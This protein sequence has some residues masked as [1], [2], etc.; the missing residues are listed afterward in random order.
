MSPTSQPLPSRRLP[1]A[2]AGQCREDSSDEPRPGLTPANT[3]AVD[4]DDAEEE[5][6]NEDEAHEEVGEDVTGDD[7]GIVFPSDLPRGSQRYHHGYHRGD[8]DRPSLL[9]PEGTTPVQGA[10]AS[11]Y[12]QDFEPIYGSPKRAGEDHIGA[13]APDFGLPH[14]MSDVSLARL[15]LKDKPLAPPLALPS[16]PHTQPF[17][18]DTTDL[19]ETVDFTEPPTRLL[20]AVNE[21]LRS[22]EDSLPPVTEDD[23]GEHASDPGDYFKHESEWDEQIAGPKRPLSRS[24]CHQRSSSVP[25]KPLKSALSPPGSPHAP[26]TSPSKKKRARFIDDPASSDISLRRTSTAPA[27]CGFANLPVTQIHEDS[28]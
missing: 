12:F 11:T 5:E 23:I 25:S 2:S 26:D 24:S 22:F 6:Q 3:W 8:D 16:V 14:R 10:A 19:V 17:V 4:V 7:S 9:M 15:D 27:D 21:H 28:S 1:Q 18:I 13:L 20:E